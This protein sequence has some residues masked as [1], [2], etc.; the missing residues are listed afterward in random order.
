MR[1]DWLSYLATAMSKYPTI[2]SSLDCSPQRISLD[3]SGLFKL[4]AEL[5]KYAVQRSR[6][7]AGKAPAPLRETSV[8]KNCSPLTAVV[9][10][11]TGCRTGHQL[12]SAHQTLPDRTLA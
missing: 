5:S 2:I 12:I 8:V 6:L 11:V 7:P 3:G 4:P 1:W 9:I 10:V